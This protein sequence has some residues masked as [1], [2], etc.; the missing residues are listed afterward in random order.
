MGSDDKR[1]R[2]E[3]KLGKENVR[4]E[5]IDI[6]EEKEDSDSLHLPLDK[7][8]EEYNEAAEEMLQRM[9]VMLESVRA[10]NNKS[11][12]G[13]RLEVHFLFYFFL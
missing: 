2:K 3:I 8:I 1:K 13:K 11:D 10:V 4:E 12:P 5:L 6:E 7:E 9:D